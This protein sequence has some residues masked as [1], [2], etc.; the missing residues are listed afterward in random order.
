MAQKVSTKRV[1]VS[2]TPQLY[3]VV[4]A[5]ADSI[6]QPTSRS[7]VDLLEELVPQLKVATQVCLDARQGRLEQASEKLRQL[8][9]ALV[10]KAV[11]A[12]KQIDLP[13]VKQE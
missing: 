11:E 13:F 10:E 6:G 9:G 8:S 3:A 5:Y 1:M 12:Q 2:M 7:I 4:K